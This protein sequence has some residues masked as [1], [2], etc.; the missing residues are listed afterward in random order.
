MKSSSNFIRSP[1]KNLYLCDWIVWTL[2]PELKSIRL[3]LMQIIWFGCPIVVYCSWLSVAK[4]AQCCGRSMVRS[5]QMRIILE[6]DQDHVY[7]KTSA[8]QQKDETHQSHS[9]VSTKSF[10]CLAPYIY[11]FVSK[12]LSSWTYHF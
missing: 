6:G 12:K 5:V 4:E 7:L 8:E 10:A 1:K 11:Y 9:V 3:R 2:L